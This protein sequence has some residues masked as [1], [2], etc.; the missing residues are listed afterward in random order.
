MSGVVIKCT[1]PIIGIRC[2]NADITSI[3]FIC[4][5]IDDIWQFNI[6]SSHSSFTCEQG[7]G[8]FSIKGRVCPTS[9]TVLPDTSTEPVTTSAPPGLEKGAIAGITVAVIIGVILLTGI[10][11]L[12]CLWKRGL[13]AGESLENPEDTAGETA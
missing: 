13:R 10:F 7:G 1:D 4:Q 6:P 11:V 5:N 2:Y 3:S 9:T 12:C 8:S